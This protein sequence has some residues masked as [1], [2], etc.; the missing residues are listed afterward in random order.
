VRLLSLD[1]DPIYDPDATRACFAGDLSV[2]DYDVAI[3]DPAASLQF[4]V[5]HRSRSLVESYNRHYRSLPRLSEYASVLIQSDAA[6]RKEEFDEFLAMGR[7]LVVIARPPQRCYVDTGKREFSGTGR[8]QKTTTILDGFDLLSVLPGDKVEF[9]KSG[10]QG[11]IVQGDGPLPR[12][13]NTYKDFI[14]YTAVISKPAG[15]IIARVA[16]ANRAVSSIQQVA[17]AGYLVLLPTLDFAAWS[18]VQE[19][20][21]VADEDEDYEPKQDGDQVEEVEEEEDWLPQ[22]RSFQYDL[23]AAIRQFTGIDGGSWPSWADLYLSPAQRGLRSDV[24]KQQKRIEAARTRLAK[25]QSQAEELEARNQLFLGTGRVLELEVKKVLELLGGVVTEPEPGKDDW[26]VSFPE[27][28]AV[29]EVKGVTKSAA[30]KQAAQLAK[31]V[32][33][34]LE[35]TGK[36]PKGLLV[37]NT[38]REIPLENRTGTDFPGQMLPYC[39][40]NEHCLITG[41]Q[42][43]VICHDVERCPDRAEFWRKAIFRASGPIADVPDWRSAIEVAD[44]ASVKRAE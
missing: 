32:A 40:R 31:W 21:E 27:G 22:A 9:V 35:E 6:R 14:R 2:F 42:L 43:L 11:I 15:S 13:L 39:K 34:G 33:A 37:V 10:G 1:Y 4:Y 41:L 30:E 44:P 3:W 5:E 24:V 19:T 17:S 26:R 16:G 29:V 23:V 25:L 20:D 38:Y 8:N 28:E 12:L 7:T 18:G 36:E